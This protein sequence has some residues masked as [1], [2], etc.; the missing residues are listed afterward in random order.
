MELMQ[1]IPLDSIQNA[2]ELGGYTM[3]DGSVIKKGLLLRTAKLSGISNEDIDRLVNRYR[4]S[5]IVDFRNAFEMPGFEDPAIPGAVYHQTDV[6]TL[7]DGLSDDDMA[8][9][10]NNVDFKQLIPMLD[11]IEG[12]KGVKGFGDWL[13]ILL[14]ADPDRAVLWHCTSGK[15]RTGL[16]AMLILSALGADEKLIMND[17]LLTNTYNAKRIA[18]LRMILRQKGMDDESLKKAALAFEAVDELFMRRSLEHLNSAYG[19]VVGYIR[20]RLGL[21]ESDIESLK[22]KYLEG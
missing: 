19:S 10:M 18:G 5:D 22:A 17:Y 2:R 9:D 13:R 7:P 3:T 16:S 21:S 15:D 14:N 1:S 4:V 6:M 8:F 12:D 11:M 20:N